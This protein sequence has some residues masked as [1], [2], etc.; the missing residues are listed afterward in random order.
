MIYIEGNIGVGKTTFLEYLLAY[1]K[2]HLS[3][4]IVLKEP[5]ESWMKTQDSNGK[6]ILE[7]YYEDQQKYGFTFQMNAFISRVHEIEEMKK[8]NKK[9]IFVERSVYTDNNVF[10]KINYK[11]GNINDIENNVYQQWFD[12][13]TDKFNLKPTG[14]IYLKTNPET[15]ANRIKKRDR[16]GESSIPL[17]YLNELDI[18]HDIWLNEEKK[19]GI[20]ILEIDV[21]IDYTT[22]STKRDEM[23][24]RIV[25]FS[26]FI[27]LN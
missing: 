25:E 2:E 26:K 18:L 21:S 16:T 8:E 3:D 10:R 12:I 23:F 7:H 17:E 4:S 9:H 5:V 15:C 1:L 27:N 14:Y 20:P 24:K 22:D 13:F 11:N 6:S 19:K